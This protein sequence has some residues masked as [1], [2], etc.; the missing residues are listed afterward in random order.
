MSSRREPQWLRDVIDNIDAIDAY[1]TDMGEADPLTDRKTV[2]ASERCLQ[3]IT[4]AII[5]IGPDRMAAIAPNVPF[6]QARGLGNMLRHQYDD[7][8]PQDLLVTISRDL[9]PLRAACVA[10]LAAITG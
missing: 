1:L 4:E 2:D 9:P 8:R 10:A 7:I 3:R 6:H 5:R